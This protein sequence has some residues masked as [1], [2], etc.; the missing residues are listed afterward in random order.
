VY[1][2]S[3]T[4]SHVGTLSSVDENGLGSSAAA[5]AT[6]SGRAMKGRTRSMNAL[7]SRRET[8]SERSG[9]GSQT[10]G[11]GDGASG[12]GRSPQRPGR[13]KGRVATSGDGAVPSTNGTGRGRISRNPED[14]RRNSRTST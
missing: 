7:G 14:R 9:N 2:E 12:G 4:A 13:G 10:N 1:P 8:Q 5:S 6:R 3:P 11:V